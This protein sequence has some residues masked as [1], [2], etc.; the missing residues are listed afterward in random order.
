MCGASLPARGLPQLC[1]QHPY[2]HNCLRRWRFWLSCLGRRGRSAI[3]KHTRTHTHTEKHIHAETHTHTEH[4]HTI[5]CTFLQSPP[6]PNAQPQAPTLSGGGDGAHRGGRGRRREQQRGR[7]RAQNK[8]RAE[9]TFLS[10][11]ISYS[12]VFQPQKQAGFCWSTPFP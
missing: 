12:S 8:H 10:L 9:Q 5:G 7:L 6:Q 3:P 1:A 4:A 11:L 2:P